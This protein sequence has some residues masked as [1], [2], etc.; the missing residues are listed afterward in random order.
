VLA[1]LMSIYAPVYL[2]AGSLKASNLKLST[3]LL[4]FV[5][6]VVLFP[7][8]LAPGF[9]PLGVEAALSLLGRT[10]GLPVCLLLSLAEW[11]GVVVL[12]RLVV[13]WQGGLLRGREQALLEAVTNRAAC[14][15]PPGIR[16]PRPRPGRE[17][18]GVRGPGASPLS[19]G[20]R[21][22]RE[23]RFGIR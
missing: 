7:L 14:P 1:N 10:G 16:P 22:R 3:G 9:L 17:G 23:G 21:G 11:A 2:S 4:Q 8:T 18:D 12:C 13:A 5:M 20:L 6:F 19:G 15:A